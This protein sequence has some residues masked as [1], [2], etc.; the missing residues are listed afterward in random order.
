MEVPTTKTPEQWRAEI[1]ALHT[2]TNERM[3]LLEAKRRRKQEIALDAANGDK[4]AI[5]ESR[6]LTTEIADLLWHIDVGDDALIVAQRHLQAAEQA[7]QDA[8]TKAILDEIARVEGV[9]D[10]RRPRIVEVVDELVELLNENDGFGRNLYQLKCEAGQ[11]ASAHALQ[12]RTRRVASNYLA[13]RL[14]ETYLRREWDSLEWPAPSLRKEAQ[15]LFA[16]PVVNEVE[17]GEE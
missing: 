9:R 7:V 16:V 12:R 5:A 10:S 3:G 11:E 17:V 1:A 8:K 14:G 15:E 2:S 4:V 6:K 13:V